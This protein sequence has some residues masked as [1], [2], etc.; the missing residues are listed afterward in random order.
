MC[1]LNILTQ[2]LSS[3]EGCLIGGLGDLLA[4]SANITKEMNRRMEKVAE[5]GSSL[6]SAGGIQG[7]TTFKS[8]SQ[9]PLIFFSFSIPRIP[10]IDVEM[11]KWQN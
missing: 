7:L 8:N 1:V 11:V 2:V 10:P 4:M 6:L 9:S 3:W 5:S